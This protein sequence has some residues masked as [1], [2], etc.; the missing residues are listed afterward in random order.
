MC[1][2]CFKKTGILFAILVSS[3][4]SAAQT[5]ETCRL[6][7]RVSTVYEEWI[8]SDRETMGMTQ[9]SRLN[10]RVS[11][12]YEEWVVSDR[13]TMGMSGLALHY[14][15][16]RRLSLGFGTWMAVRG[17]RGGFITLGVDAAMRWP[18]TDRLEARTGLFLGAGGGKN[19]NVLAGGGLMLR[20]HARL[21]WHAAPW[22]ALSAGY[23][24]TTFPLGGIISSAQPLAEVAIPVP[25]P[26]NAHRQTKKAGK[27]QETSI[28]TVTR[29]IK[30]TADSRRTGGRPQQ[31]ITLL[32]IELRSYLNRNFFRKIETQ[33]AVGGDNSG[34]MQIL[35]GMGY[36]QKISNRLSFSA[37]VS[38]GGAGGGAVETG[39]GVLLNAGTSV[40]VNLTRNLFTGL[41]GT[42]STAPNGTFA[43]PGYSIMAGY[44]T[45]GDRSAD[46]RDPYRMRVRF[47]NDTYLRADPDWRA[48][49]KDTQVDNLG[50]Q[51]D[52]Y[53]SKS[54]YLTGQGI[55]AYRGKA[56]AYMIGL[57]GAGLTIP[58]TERLFMNAE[59]L[60][61]A[62]GGGGLN[63]G[64]GL[65]WQGNAGPGFRV[66]PHLSIMATAGRVE[67][68]NGPFKANVLSLALTWHFGL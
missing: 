37:D 50:I 9:T 47:V 38:A 27:L 2:K 40:Q 63:T 21:S 1:F 3:A 11:T 44:R 5:T 67:S 24:Y 33:G 4:T 68:F 53:I 61:G 25:L 39:G 62:A 46:R 36:Q 43:G 7:E 28:A 8:V 17:D 58:A 65:V 41:A 45:G 64:S 52:V 30:P 18:L 59:G 12:I 19:G 49:Y 23:S 29:F 32:G 20:P 14:D 15:A 60:V 66:N 55:A 35:A 26:I 34:Y 10:G 31:D 51:F 6:N 22:L 54:A 57:L 42:W 16:T 48:S 56:G 13:E